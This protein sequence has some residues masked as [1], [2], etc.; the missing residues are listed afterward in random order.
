[1][2]NTEISKFLYMKTHFLHKIIQMPLE[3]RRENSYPFKIFKWEEVTCNAGFNKVFN[4][5]NNIADFDFQTLVAT[6]NNFQ[7]FNL[8]SD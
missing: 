1:M 8:Y 6:N 7:L 3:P 5:L 2:K 4:S